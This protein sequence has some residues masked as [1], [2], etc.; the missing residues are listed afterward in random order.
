MKLNL[1]GKAALLLSVVGSC[2]LSDGVLAAPSTFTDNNRDL[3]LTFRKTGFDGTGTAG[4]VVFEVDIGQAS[5]YYNATPGHPIPVTA[6]DKTAQLGTLFDSLNDLSWSVGGCVPNTGD[7][8]DPSKPARTLW[9]TDPR[10]G[11]PGVSQAPWVRKSTYTQGQTGSH[12]QAILI[13]AGYWAHAYPG[14]PVTNSSTALAIPTGNG[15]NAGG[16]LGAVGNYLGTFAGD[17]ENTTPP[18]FTLESNPSQSDFYELQP[19]GGV[20]KYL[21]YFE[22]DNDGSMTFYPQVAIAYPAPTLSIAP[23][24]AGNV[25]ISFQS[26]ANGTY[27]LH[28]TNDAGLTTPVGSWPT[29]GSVI[30]GDGGIDT[31]TQPIGAGNT[32]FSVT[33]H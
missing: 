3:I 17:V 4:S 30:I 13:N 25:R 6:Y 7:N 15:Y 28:G 32:Y 23:D 10:I 22:L 24:G 29:V 1:H 8:G 11:D 2:A 19:G 5:I 26:T 9:L 18:A 14:D 21:G 16:S 27:T 12:V 20:G 31:F 33:V